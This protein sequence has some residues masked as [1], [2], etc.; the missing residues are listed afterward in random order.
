MTGTL[1]PF[2]EQ[3]EHPDANV[4]SQA[5][6]SLGKLADASAVPALLHRLYAEADFYVREDITWSL[7]RMGKAALA[8]LIDLLRH[9]NPAARVHAAHTLSKIG[10]P[11]AADA[12]IHALRD[13]DPAVISKAAFALIALLGHDHHEVHTTVSSV[14][15]RYGT[16]ALPLLAAALENPDWRV[17]EQAADIMGLIESDEAVPALIGALQD[18]HGAVTALGHLGGPDVHRAL[19]PLREDPDQRVRLLKRMKA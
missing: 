4:R 2:I 3:L 18:E 16:E 6:L 17:R 1:Y 10:D 14:L 12:L 7:V 15:E 11:H 19:Q 5:V 13:H 9:E 8:P